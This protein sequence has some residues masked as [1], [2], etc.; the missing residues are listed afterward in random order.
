MY[1]TLPTPKT[2]WSQ[3]VSSS[4]FGALSPARLSIHPHL[5]IVSRLNYWLSLPDG[6]PVCGRHWDRDSW[7]DILAFI[8]TTCKPFFLIQVS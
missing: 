6:C 4:V 8:V 3:H 1:V 5:M 2:I 7:G